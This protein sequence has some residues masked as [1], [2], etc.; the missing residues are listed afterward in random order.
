MSWIGNA[1][2]TGTVVHQR[3]RPVG[4]RLEYRVA[5]LL[6]DVDELASAQLPLIFSYNRFNLFS[7]HDGD[8][9]A[10][11]SGQ[12]ISEFAWGHVKACGLGT[13]VRRIFMLSYPR[14][15][16]YVFNPLTTYF[17]LDGDGHIRLVIYEV[18]NTFGGRHCY[19]AGP[20]VPGDVAYGQ[21]E[22]VFRVSPFNGVEGQYG[23]KASLD[24]DSATVGVSLRTD[25]GPVLKAY[26]HGVRRAFS[27]WQLLRVFFGLPLMTLKVI[28][29]IHWEALKLFLKGLK[30]HAP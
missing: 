30:L 28:G 5:S 17:A 6:I 21:A 24:G 16:G 1:L 9:G 20:F 8:H 14:M 12:T 10:L 2:Y 3:L 11:S 15:L 29:G 18:H 25:D 13:I 26:F 22:K 19:M 7:I 27:S 4:H 23:L